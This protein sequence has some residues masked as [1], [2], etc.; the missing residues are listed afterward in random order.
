MHKRVHIVFRGMVQGVGFRYTSESI[1]GSLGVEGWVRNVPSGEV[2]LVVEQ[3]ESVLNDFI[4]RLED[5]FG[6]YIKDK[7]VDWSTATGEFDGFRIE[8]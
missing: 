7:Q 1:A 8:F 4:C 5:E 6:G 2:E 3:E